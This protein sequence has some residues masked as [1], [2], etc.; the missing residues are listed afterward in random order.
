[1]LSTTRPIQREYNATVNRMGWSM[2]LFIGLFYALN[3]PAE[4]FAMEAEAYIH[5]VIGPLLTILSGVISTVAYMTPFIGAGIFF[6]I[7]SKK[8][9]TQR[10]RLEL[11]LPPIF[12]L[13][14]LAGLAV[15]TVGSYLNSFFCSLIGYTTTQDTTVLPDYSNPANVIRYMTTAIAPAF[16]EEFL[17]RGVYYTNLRPYGRTQAV[18]ISA[19]LFSLMHMNL[20][21][22]IYTFMAG[23]VMAMMYE[24]TASIWCCILFHLL[25]NELAVI[26]EI[27]YYGKLGEACYDGLVLMD[28]LEVVLGSIAIILLFVFRARRRRHGAGRCG[29][30]HHRLGRRRKALREGREVPPVAG[31]PTICDHSASRLSSRR[32][33]MTPGMIVFTSVVMGFLALALISTLL[34]K[35]G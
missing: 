23:I 12:P 6:L 15:I 22:I 4:L 32:A 31:E 8:A 21:Q 1:M 27:L 16:A 18:L 34:G 7:L 30:R 14:I 9:P 35:I 3:I 5:P 24:L 2:F 29:D 28:V 25:N 33:L 10:M 17:F 19:L 26:A 20:A 11:T 13:L